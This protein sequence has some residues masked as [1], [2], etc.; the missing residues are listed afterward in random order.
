[1]T[2]CRTDNQK[3]K[4]P[5]WLTKFNFTQGG[6]DEKI[7]HYFNIRRILRHSVA[8]T[9]F[10][11]PSRRKFTKSNGGGALTNL[12]S[13]NASSQA[14]SIAAQDLG[15]RL[16]AAS[17]TRATGNRA[18]TRAS[19]QRATTR[20]GSKATRANQRATKA[21]QRQAAQAKTKSQ[22]RKEAQAQ[23]FGLMPS[24]LDDMNRE[25][26]HADA[27]AIKGARDT[28]SAMRYLPFVT[29]V[30]T[31]GFGNGFDLRG[32]GRLSANG[33]KFK[34]NGID[35]T[36]VDSYYGF[37]PINT[38]LP[39][40]I[41]QIDV[42]PGA[43]ARG[44][45]I[46]VITSQRGAPVF[47]VGAGYVNTMATEGNSFNAYALA[48][49]NFGPHL[50]A[51]AGLALVQHGG[52]REDDTL[53][54][55]QAVIGAW[56]DIGWGQSV[57]LDVDVFYGKN[58]TSPYASFVR[59]DRANAILTRADADW[60]ANNTNND[61]Q[62]TVML[63]EMVASSLE[64]DRNARANK[65]YGE[66]ETT[67]IRALG[68][69]GW[70]N[71]LTQRLK[72][73][74]S[75]F[76]LMNNRKFDKYEMYVPYFM[77]NGMRAFNPKPGGL[78]GDKG[79]W[80]FID[81][82]GSTFNENKFGGSAVI[83]WKHDKG[84][85]RVGYDAMYAMNKRTPQQYLRQAISHAKNNPLQDHNNNNGI[86]HNQQVWIN[87]LLD[88][89]KFSSSIF[90]RENYNL[91]RNFSVMGG[92]RYEIMNYDIKA[93]DEI[94]GGAYNVNLNDNG[95]WTYQEDLSKLS[96]PEEGTAEK[97]YSK[98]YDNF[99]FELAPVFRYSNTGL[100]FARAETGWQAPPAYGILQ[101]KIDS[102]L[103]NANAALQ[104][105]EGTNKVNGV[106][107][108]YR[109]TDLKD[110]TYYTAEIGWK[111]MIGTR[112][113][114]L[115]FTNL[116][117][118]AL[119]FS[120]TGFYSASQNEF[121]FNGD[122]YSAMEFGTWDKSRRMGVEVA[123]EQY[124]FDGALSFNE[125]FTFIKA[126]KFGPVGVWQKGGSVSVNQGNNNNNKTAPNPYANYE[127]INCEEKWDDIP[128]SYNYKATLGAAVDV[129][130]F[131][132]VIDVSVS[133][134]LQN[135]IYGNQRVPSRTQTLRTDVAACPDGICNTTQWG[136]P[137]NQDF[138]L[139]NVTDKEEK[140]K[141]Y[142]ISDFGISVGLNKNM[143]MVTIGIKNLFDTYYYDYYNHDQSASINENRY[144]VGRGRTVFI[145]G[146]FK[147]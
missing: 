72:L 44:G 124:L 32:Q 73:D 4:N 127:C 57:T 91:T 77:F 129:A 78:W 34:I 132:E 29:I 84:V 136:Q 103:I 147:Y 120:V 74:V 80:Q 99:L 119:L 27:A 123:A 131:L 18:T 59:G 116:T 106:G 61:R 130:G 108:S 1:M 51:N 47:I 126:Q 128:Y 135:S 23:Q 111:E 67:Q 9:S 79:D 86:S 85:L 134:W 13:S 22:E 52:P 94:Y 138:Y 49:E 66:I 100:I 82:T 17:N 33:L 42:L 109:E 19:S 115:G 10:C 56:Y 41:Q 14:N 12:V 45:T 8:F 96:K 107:I 15:I 26:F 87:N 50:K 104:K 20:T 137:G 24:E 97:E 140:L 105:Y 46:N 62:S 76:Y 48:N 37:M 11:S 63:Q 31:A 38:V 75:A 121:Y 113:V 69:L 90:I 114:P 68:V 6:S 16:A 21:A 43:E 5:Y 101:R 3:T 92:F 2:K 65:G 28:E 83:D 39:S 89:K 40:L 117:L 58:K 93:K 71:Q 98:N 95:D 25:V 70:Q 36:P 88:I 7:H 30:N 53:Q 142:I 112:R 122:P 55:G 144:V 139:T 143:G 54:S 118:N 64:E 110:E 35:V 133:I 81:Q 102:I 145:E 141:P 60:T 146:Q 125:S